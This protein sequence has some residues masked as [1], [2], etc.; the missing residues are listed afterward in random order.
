VSFRGVTAIL[1]ILRDFFPQIQ[2]VPVFTTVRLWVIR[3][4][5]YKLNMFLERAHDWAIILDH[6]IQIGQLKVLIVL[7]LRLSNLPKDRALALGDVQPLLVLPMKSSTG[8]RIKQVL[9]SV[10]EK[11]G[12]IR[13]TVAD[14]GPDIKLG[15][16][17][18]MSENKQVDY[19]PDIV[20]TLGHLLNSELS[21]NSSWQLLNKKSSV[22][23]IKLLQSQYAHLIPPQRRDKARYLN[24]EEL[25]KWAKRVLASFT[26]S[27]IS[28]EDREGLIKHFSW[29]YDI[30][31]DIIYFEELWNIVAITRD[32]IRTKDINSNS[33]EELASL[34]RSLSLSKRALQFATKVL[35]FVLIQSSKA[36]PGERLLGSTE[37]IESLIGTLK[38][39]LNSQSRS[40]FTGSV[41]MTSTLVG[42]VNVIMTREA[43]ESI[44]VKEVLDWAA[45]FIGDTIQ[46]KRREF[47]ESSKNHSVYHELESGTENGNII[48]EKLLLKTG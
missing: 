36:E 40:G 6:T 5:L 46:K 11:Y 4:G 45:A 15:I 12:S 38:Q 1:K 25:I 17:L 30:K 20:H 26:S 44:S 10:K 35:D 48:E 14:G 9:D 31:T 47:Q 21:N 37:V 2:K 18:F 27:E 33:G 3:Y 24:L 42:E 19:V 32:L 41:L 29:I 13:L 39:R 28:E 23:R 34:L 7:G 43:M 16:K 8:A 22:R